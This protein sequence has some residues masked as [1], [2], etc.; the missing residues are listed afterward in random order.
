LTGLVVLRA[1]SPEPSA[2]P[3]VRGILAAAQCR[4]S[5]PT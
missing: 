1:L 5:P 3:V 4:P 2:T